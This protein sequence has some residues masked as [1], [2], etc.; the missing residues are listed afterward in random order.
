MKKLLFILIIFVF[1][2][3][4]CDAQNIVFTDINFK[5]KLLMADVFNSIASN[6]NNQPLKIDGNN[7]SEISFL[8][9][10]QVGYLFLS[11]S[12]ISNLIGIEHFNNLKNL[13]VQL[14]P[15]NNIDTTAMLN[16]VGLDC[17][18]T[19]LSS[20]NLSGM[21]NLNSVVCS[22]NNISNL[23]FTGLPN[24]RY[25]FCSNNQLTTLDFSS[26]PLFNELICSNNNLININIKNGANQL[27]NIPGYWND[28]WKIGNPNLTTICADENEVVPLTTFLT[29]CNSG[30]NP[31]IDSSC[32]LASD[33]F[34]KNEFLVYPN[35]SDGIYLISFKSEI[36]EAKVE[37]YSLLG[38]Q[39][40]K[41]TIFETN[42]KSINLNNFA[43]GT[44]LIKIIQDE[45][46]FD[47]L[48]IKK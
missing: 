41:E 31:S 3:Y 22:N 12:N 33:Q 28:C 8:E 38:Q 48:I 24:L 21:I 25:L 26:N 15:L 10:Q 13:S 7:D 17:R 42:Q 37:V 23:D 30:A 11:N 2:Q 47:S 19:N 43:S 46:T 9:A 4:N 32:V 27:I 44:Y 34:V 39:L 45:N 35:P 1:E 6:I 5:N 40:F 18:Y 36:K 20:L 14:N 16:L 29:S